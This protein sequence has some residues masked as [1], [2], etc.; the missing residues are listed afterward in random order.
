MA[1]VFKKLKVLC[2]FKPV[3]VLQYL[4]AIYSRLMLPKLEWQLFYLRKCPDK[5][6][7]ATCL[8][9]A[10]KVILEA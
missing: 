1:K 8:P 6:L 7:T 10:I 2:I 5:G 9:L 4:K 3:Q